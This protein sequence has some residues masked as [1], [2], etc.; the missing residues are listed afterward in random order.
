MFWSAVNLRFLFKLVIT[1]LCLVKLTPI[2]MLGT[3]PS[4]WIWPFVD[5]KGDLFFGESALSARFETNQL[6]LHVWSKF[7]RLDIFTCT[8]NR[9]KWA[10]YIL[11]FYRVVK[12][13]VLT[14]ITLH[15][16]EPGAISRAG[17]VIANSILKFM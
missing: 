2:G 13:I 17:R 5:S 12:K 14:R 3:I 6:K 4:C 8:I 9:I 7:H 10:H 11:H 15:L 1:R 16:F